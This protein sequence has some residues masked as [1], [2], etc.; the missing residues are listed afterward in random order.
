MV[1]RV[2]GRIDG[3][4]IKSLREFTDNKKI[5]KGRLAID[6]TDVTLVS[7]KAVEALAIA[8]AK[9]IELKNCPD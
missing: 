2:S 5:P 7:L 8:E 1:L 4:Y 6:L 3:T 9:G